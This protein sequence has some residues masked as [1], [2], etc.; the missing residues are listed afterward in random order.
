MEVNITQNKTYRYQI[1]CKGKNP[2]TLLYVLHGY[3]QLAKYFIQKFNHLQN[4]I[5]VA[6]EGGHRFYLKG[7][8]GRVGA[9][10]MTKEARET[11]ISDNINYLDSLDVQLSKKF[12]ID[13]K[14][15]I[16]FSQGGATAIR[17]RNQSAINFDS[18][19]IWASDYPKDS[20]IKKGNDYFIIGDKDEFIH[21]EIKVQMIKDYESKGFKICSYIGMH[22]I[23]KETLNDLLKTIGN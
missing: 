9:S 4:I 22:D 2:T 5:V 16:G 12:S 8:G 3:G 11:D 1:S 21:S 13:K 15:L 19:I 17:W 10:W 18:L 6:P 23:D 20:I 7:T 14:I